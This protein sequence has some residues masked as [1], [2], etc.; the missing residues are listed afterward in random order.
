MTEDDL[1]VAITDMAVVLGWH[2]LHVGALRTKYGWKTPT[3]GTLAAW[4]DLTLARER[5][6]RLIFAELKRQVEEPRADQQAVLDTLEAVADV[7]HR[8][9]DAPLRRVAVHVWRPSDLRDPIE[10]SPIYEVLR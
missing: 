3:R 5:D 10:S 2:W 8:V 4:P 6:G 1:Q 9:S 7:I